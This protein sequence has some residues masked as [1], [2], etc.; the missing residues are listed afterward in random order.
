MSHLQE[1]IHQADILTQILY[2]RALVQL[3]L[4]A[5]R[6]G[7]VKET[8]SSLQEIMNSGRVKELLAQGTSQRMHSAEQEKVEK[9]RQLPFHMHV[10]LELL[11]C[12]YLV[13]SMLLE[14]PVMAQSEGTAE[15]RK[16]IIS[17]L[18]RRM[19]DNSERMIFVGPPEN[20]REHVIAA[21]KALMAGEWSECQ[22]FIKAI[23]I[24]DL[25][26]NAASIKEMLCD[27]I[28]Q[29]ALRTYLFTYGPFY[30]TMRLDHLASMF[31]MTEHQ[32]RKIVS[33]MIYQEELTGSL[34]QVNALVVLT[35]SEPSRL[36][37]IA[38]T[39]ADKVSFMVDMNEKV[40]ESKLGSGMDVKAD[41]DTAMNPSADRKGGDRKQQKN[42]GNRQ[43][44]GRRNVRF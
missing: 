1:S 39:L 7:M 27:K 40:M 9:Q 21:S 10:N 13:C 34:D 22:H 32:V 19:L 3:G 37:Q 2:N 25:M 11:E 16:R 38:V 6:L 18:F 26:P 41:R 17:K 23:K 4:C 29:E 36:Q 20:T 24:W 42:A 33:G 14:V 43:K 44:G 30:T 35:S 28:Q 12:V 5:F 8:Q 31:G 15:A